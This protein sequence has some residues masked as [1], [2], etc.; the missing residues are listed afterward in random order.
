MLKL[1]CESEVC[2]WGYAGW[3]IPLGTG[4]G[5]TDIRGS[6]IWLV[7]VKASVYDSDGVYVLELH[8]SDRNN[9]SLFDWK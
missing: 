8:I 1:G 4:G 5:Y 9:M 2:E 7:G 3:R 6:L